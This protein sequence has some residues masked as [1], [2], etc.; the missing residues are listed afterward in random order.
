MQTASELLPTFNNAQAWYGSDMVDRSDWIH[1]LDAQEI[2]E[3][4][5]AIAIFEKNGVELVG[6]RR[7]DFPLPTLAHRLEDLKQQLLNGRGFMLV[8][9]VPVHRYTT[10]Q[11][12]AAFLGLG[13]YLGEPV[14]Q[15]GK[16]HILGHVKN[17]G[18]DFN[19]PETRGYQTNSQLSFHTDFSDL[20]GLLCLHTPK[21][22]GES[23]IASST[24]VWNEM[25]QRQPELA[26]ALTA[27]VCYTRWGEVLPGEK[28]YSEVP[29][30]APLEDRVIAFFNARRTIMKAQ[31]F[32]EV[33]RITTEQL[34]ALTLLEDIVHDPSI[35]MNMVLRQ[36]DM[37]F[38]CNHY[39]FHTRTGYEDWPEVERRRHLLRLWL[40]CD[41]GPALPSCLMDSQG[42]T[43]GGRPAGIHVAGVPMIAPL[44]AE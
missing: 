3:L 4:D 32:P 38:L 18:V 14:S 28:R 44:E 1:E 21:S 41:D 6:M 25:V 2:A 43:P 30:F 19:D 11:S 35:H 15:N 26:R 7:E 22:G 5:D 37:Q 42:S 40:A 10:R 39:I 20:V 9:N 36:G 34:D 17:L 8:R 27:P 23:S 33:P 29:V 16:G 13:R 31:A 12:A 24:T